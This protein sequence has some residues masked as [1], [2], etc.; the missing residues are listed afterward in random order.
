M[1]YSEAEWTMALLAHRGEREHLMTA[2]EGRLA[3]LALPLTPARRRVNPQ[4]QAALSR[5]R[6][7]LEVVAQRLTVRRRILAA[8]GVA[9]PDGIDDTAATNTIALLRWQAGE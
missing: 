2:I 6:E 7:E 1:N 9:E 4:H 3:K 8:A 5:L